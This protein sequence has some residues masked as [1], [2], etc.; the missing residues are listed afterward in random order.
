MSVKIHGRLSEETT[1]L[2]D[3]TVQEKAITYPTDIKLAIKISNHLKKLAKA[4]GIKQKRTYVKE[5]KSLRLAC[6]HFRH[7]KVRAKAKKALRR[8]HTIAGILIR[9]L[10]RKL[11]P[12]MLEAQLENFKLYRK[13]LSHK[14][15]DKNKIYSLHEPYIYCIGKGKDHKP[16][17]YGR[18]TFVVSTLKSQAIVGVES[19]DD[20][21]HDSNT[22]K[23]ALQSAHEFR[24]K[25]IKLAVVDRGYRGSKKKVDTEVLLPS[26]PLKRDT[27]YQRQKKRILCRKVTANQT[28]L[29]KSN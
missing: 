10:E 6:R 4:L 17:E 11:S 14:P 15:K 20:H 1:V 28:T 12:S 8:L 5:I 25:D 16:Y 26:P 9:E 13:V 19:H 27:V 29:Y 18:K 21:E 23:S 22:L 2:V 7:V 3:T 24:E